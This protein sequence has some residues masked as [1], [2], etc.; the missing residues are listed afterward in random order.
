MDKQGTIRAI[1]A[2]AVLLFFIQAVRT[3]FSVLF[4]V[5]YDAIFAG[6]LTVGAVVINVLVLG[7]FLVPLLAPRRYARQ[8]LTVSSVLVYLARIPMTVNDPQMRLYSSLLIVAAGGLYA[9]SLLTVA[10]GL[11]PVSLM[12]ALAFDQLLRAWGNTFDVTLR[13]G[14]LP[15][16]L[17]ISAVLL[18]LSVRAARLRRVDA[19]E[20]GLGLLGGMAVGGMLFLQTSLLSLPNAIARWSA[21][22]YSALVP[23]LL[24]VTLLPLLW[25][26]LR[27]AAG[28]VTGR[29]L[30]GIILLLLVCGG[31]AAGYLLT[32]FLAAVALLVA[33]LA[34]LL[35]LPSLLR[36]TRVE[37]QHSGSRLAAGLLLFLAMNFA[38]AF[39][40]TYAYTLDLFRGAGLP[41]FL[42]A[43]LFTTLPAALRGLR[44]PGSPEWGP[45]RLVVGVATVMVALSLAFAFPSALQ[46]KEA[47]P[48]V[49]VATYNIHYGYHS[50]WKFYL[51]EMAQTIEQ[52]GADIVAMQEV[53]TG[54]ITSYC[55][56]DALWLA[57]Q[58]RMGVY[59][60]PTVEHLT[61]IAVLYRFP[62]Q[63]AD[64]K[65]LTSR[66]EQ[67]GI[68]RTR[69][70]VGDESLDAYGIW[71]GLER[72]ERAVQL[73]EALDFIGQGSAVFGGDLNST[74]DSPVYERLTGA[75]FLDPFIA[76]GFE[77]LPTSP[78]E[79][80]EERI[81]YVWIR[82]LRPV[83][84][85]VPK[86]T[87]SDHRMVVVEVAL[88]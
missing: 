1:E 60:L 71:L 13:A 73:T 72:E 70:K 19:P 87:A 74:P 14:W 24:V 8:L 78:S 39:A 59:Y 76:G 67:T 37:G 44:L 77:P 42:L 63:E 62:V 58:L 4:G 21:W 34:V 30:W 64:G 18:V 2:S 79:E 11:L 41:I 51:E 50:D 82:G 84:A 12:A 26:A 23:S 57:R 48:N 54:R 61:G 17:A 53:D 66:L 55:V 22:S 27:P 6:P 80:P 46:M 3:L 68:I 88:Q 36:E 15:V 33:Q 75:G 35:A 25:G 81:D 38:N 47:G 20:L 45:A 29:R 16:Q 32:G 52:S 5:I 56:D 86:S 65:L 10:P 83:D 40:F 7:A 9:A 49:R 69:L 31:L 85:Q 43:G 28:E